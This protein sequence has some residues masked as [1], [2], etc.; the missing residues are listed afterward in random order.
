MVSLAILLAAAPAQLDTPRMPDPEAYGQ[1]NPDDLQTV[2]IKASQVHFPE[3]QLHG[4]DYYD[5]QT[6]EFLMDGEWANAKK[7][8]PKAM[9]FINY[10]GFR[11]IHELLMHH[12]SYE[13]VKKLC[14]HGADVNARD[15]HGWHPL[16]TAA[17]NNRIGA[18]RALLECGA[19]ASVLAH[20]YHDESEYTSEFGTGAKT[21]G[22]IA[23]DR[24][25]ARRAMRVARPA[26]DAPSP[27]A[28]VRGSRE[29]PRLR[30]AVRRAAAAAQAGRRAALPRRGAG[31]LVPVARSVSSVES[32][33]T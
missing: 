26:A 13:Y 33:P 21:A 24:V 1:I 15:E 4:D 5:F 27:A 17:W 23:R 19:D 31:A 2:N 9:N 29:P 25:S 8:K 10:M 6:L 12:D 22:R 14:E 16:A 32:S 18:A 30:R 3:V 20:V 11:P 7:L 28:G